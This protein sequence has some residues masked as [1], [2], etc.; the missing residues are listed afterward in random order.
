ML[1]MFY[2]LSTSLFRIVCPCS[3]LSVDV[4]KWFDLQYDLR[5][6]LSLLEYF[7]IAT[8]LNAAL[9]VLSVIV[10]LCHHASLKSDPDYESADDGSLFGL[11]IGE[12]CWIEVEWEV[13]VQKSGRQT[14]QVRSDGYIYR[15]R[16]RAYHYHGGT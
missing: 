3:S 4:C 1:Y 7:F 9:D 15:R 6:S 14:Q 11:E 2:R 8:F 5:R 16:I 10:R 12:K 13:E